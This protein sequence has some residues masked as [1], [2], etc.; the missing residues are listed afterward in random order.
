MFWYDC[1]RIQYT[2]S[3]SIK[4]IVPVKLFVLFGYPLRGINIAYR[5][6][7]PTRGRAITNDW[8]ISMAISI[9]RNR[10]T[11]GSDQRPLYDQLLRTT[12][13]RTISRRVR[14]PIVRSVVASG[15]RSYDQS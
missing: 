10:A 2:S 13:D 5:Q 1:R 3:T 11:S 14:R 9:V 6:P 12:T 4:I 15:H 7:S 8:R